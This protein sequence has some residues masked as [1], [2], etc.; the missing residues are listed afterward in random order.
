MST[1]L[2]H[3]WLVRMRGGEKVLETLA[4][5]R[6]EA[7]LF[8]LVCDYPRLS[9]ALR[10]RTIRTSWIDALPGAAR[11]YP[12]LLPLHPAA[13]ASLDLRGRDLVITNDSSLAKTIRVP[14]GAVHVCHC[15]T[16]PRYLWDMT[17]T[18][19]ASVGPVQRAAARA[20]IPRLRRIDRAAADRVHHFIAISGHVRERI[21]RHYERESV[22]IHPPVEPFEPETAPPGGFYLAV[23]QLVTYKRMDLAVD[24]AR[25]LGRKL[26]VIGEGPERGRLER[27]A[28]PDA[29]FL[30]WQDDAAV[31]RHYAACRALLFPGEEDFGIVPVEAQM[32]GRPVIAFRKG[33]ALETVVED[34]T[35]LFFDRQD[36]EALAEAMQAFERRESDFDAARIRSHAMRFE[37]A[38]FR[39]AFTRFLAGLGR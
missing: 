16:P 18:Y 39:E 17:E 2:V 25:R 31:R 26:V 23:G 11:R 35:G 3:P 1:A 34:E 37:T 4:A 14:P 28:G 22:V 29:T 7:D 33:G 38:A 24:A 12:Q 32:A 6:P 20:L 27:M 5:L 21:R 13:Y 9:E 19:L 10:R 36:P 8:T 30:G 15:L